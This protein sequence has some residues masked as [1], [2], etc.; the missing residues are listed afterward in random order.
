[1]SEV[2]ESFVSDWCE[3][4]ELE[5]ETGAHPLYN[6][7]AE[8]DERI[9][10]LRR[11]AVVYLAISPN[12]LL[13]NIAV[14]RLQF[15]KVVRARLVMHVMEKLLPHMY[16]GPKLAPMIARLRAT[17]EALAV[18]ARC[19]GY[20]PRFWIDMHDDAPDDGFLQLGP[21]QNLFAN[22]REL[23]Q[24]CEDIQ[25]DPDSVD[26]LNHIPIYETYEMDNYCTSTD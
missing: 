12:V 16:E 26:D 11:F 19:V 1:M 18:E 21:Y 17:E 25:E 13:G 9:E 4:S 8:I 2:V 22:D 20:A 14:R 5:E 3:M 7:I 15:F 24:V 23:E 6:A 10:K